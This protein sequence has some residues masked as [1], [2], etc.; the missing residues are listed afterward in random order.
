M[1]VKPTHCGFV[2]VR[3]APWLHVVVTWIL[4]TTDRIV[5]DPDGEPIVV[6]QRG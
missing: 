1:P 5:T 2:T 4:Q 3:S 6:T